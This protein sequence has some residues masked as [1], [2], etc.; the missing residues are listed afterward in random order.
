MFWLGLHH[1]VFPNI[2]QHRQRNC[3]LAEV[4]FSSDDLS[5]CK[6]NNLS[7]LPAMT[8]H[9]GKAPP[10]STSVLPFTD[11]KAFCAH[12]FP[13][14]IRKS[15]KQQWGCNWA[16]DVY[17]ATWKCCELLCQEVI[18]NCAQLLKELNFSVLYYW[19]TK[20]QSNIFPFIKKHKL[21]FRQS[22][23]TDEENSTFEVNAHPHMCHRSPGGVQRPR[24]AHLAL[25]NLSLPD[26]WWTGLT[27]MMFLG[28]FTMMHNSGQPSHTIIGVTQEAIADI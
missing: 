6:E 4:P 19:F 27:Q 23:L 7:V 21:C 18:L 16:L 26:F 13:L 2:Q 10:T 3:T 20:R 8:I 15:G 25:K 14:T 9:T 24:A 17:T 22:S 11:R 28:A 1:T 5:L 12:L